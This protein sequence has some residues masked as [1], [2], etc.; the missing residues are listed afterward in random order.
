MTNIQKKK[1]SAKTLPLAMR[2]KISCLSQL[3]RIVPEDHKRDGNPVDFQ[4]NGEVLSTTCEEASRTDADVT[5]VKG[6]E[7]SHKV[8]NSNGLERENSMDINL[9]R[10]L[11]NRA[12]V[13]GSFEDM[14]ETQKE[15]E[16]KFTEK[17]NKSS[18]LVYMPLPL[19]LPYVSVFFYLC[20]EN[21]FSHL[22]SS[23]L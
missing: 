13:I 19:P 6:D 14:E 16:K 22:V 12:R 23:W 1:K 3:S 21:F 10:A 11:K 9:E 5:L 8:S 2:L 15:W 20:P 18:A 7:S 4:E 17:E